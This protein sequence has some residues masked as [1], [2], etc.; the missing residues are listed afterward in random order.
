[1]P[2][3]P[4]ERPAQPLHVLESSVRPGA[5]LD[6]TLG[7]SGVRVGGIKSV[8]MFQMCCFLI[9]NTMPNS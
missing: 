7:E 9:H 3:A 5:L 2:G 4:D 6:Q 8:V 1:M